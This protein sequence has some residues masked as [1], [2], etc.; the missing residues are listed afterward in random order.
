MTYLSV[1]DSTTLAF[2]SV[3]MKIKLLPLD[4][5]PCDFWDSI[6]LKVW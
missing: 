4:V 6:R 3:G 2:E 1:Y 5:L